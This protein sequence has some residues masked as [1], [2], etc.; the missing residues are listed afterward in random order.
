MSSSK[1]RLALVVGLPLVLAGAPR[2]S[3]L[4]LQ[5][6]AFRHYVEEFNW[7]DAERKTNCIDNNDIPFFES[8]DK[9]LESSGKGAGVL[10]FADGEEIGSSP[11]LEWFR[12]KLSETRA[13]WKKYER[14]STSGFGCSPFNVPDL[15]YVTLVN[16]Y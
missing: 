14:Q 12:V 2:Q 4:V 6:G 3:T 9:E 10:G 5:P 1:A 11:R 15:K 16:I 13:G 7:N 8:S